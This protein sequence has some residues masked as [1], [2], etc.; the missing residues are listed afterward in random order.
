MFKKWRILIYDIPE[1][2]RINRAYQNNEDVPSWIETFE[3][4]DIIY[5]SLTQQLVIK[6]ETFAREDSYPIYHYRRTLF[7]CIR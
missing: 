3:G 5:R 1:T 4:L 2:R 7:A 6:A